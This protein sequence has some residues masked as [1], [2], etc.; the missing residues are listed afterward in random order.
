MVG[1]PRSNEEENM[2]TQER[3]EAVGGTRTPVEVAFPETAP[4]GRLEL[5]IEAGAC[6]LSIR[7]TTGPASA[8]WM[9]G[10]YYDPTASLPLSV[11]HEGE[12]LKLVVG[13]NFLD[14]IGLV[15]GVPELSLMLS[16]RYPYALSID[17][18]ASGMVVDLGGL[19]ITRL[20]V[21]FGAGTTELEFSAPNPAQMSLLKVGLGAGEI[22]ARNLANANFEE[23]TVGGGAANYELDFGGTL[24]RNGYVNIG[25]AM[26]SVDL[27]IP[28]ETPARIVSTIVLGAPEVDDGFA[29]RDGVYWTPAALEGRTPMLRLHNSVSLGRLALRSR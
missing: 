21:H 10:E 18:G 24:R 8:L 2:E 3:T 15:P 19:P 13:R 17:A 7:P 23:M 4:G 27:R 6:K 11:Q 28:R 26:S 9:S 5:R 16:N 14:R 22:K 25:T 12:R 20:E 1:R 29:Y